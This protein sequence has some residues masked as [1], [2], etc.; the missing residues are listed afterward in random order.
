[1]TFNRKAQRRFYW[2]KVRSI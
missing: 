2:A 1:M